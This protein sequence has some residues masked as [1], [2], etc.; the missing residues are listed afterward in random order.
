MKRAG[1]IEELKMDLDAAGIKYIREFLFAHPRKWRA[2][3]LIA[4]HDLLI[5]VEGGT[6][7]GGRHTSGKG[8]RNDCEKYNAAVLLGYRVL[9]FTADMVR[10][11]CLDVIEEAMRDAG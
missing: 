3:F 10:D 8:Y 4:G 7:N 2:D 11:G 9:R 1:G 5:E 6:W